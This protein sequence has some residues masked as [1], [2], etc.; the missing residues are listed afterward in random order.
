MR[1][2]IFV[3]RFPVISE[4]FI[5]SKVLAL[6]EAGHDVHLFAALPD[7][8]WA[9]YPQLDALRPMLEA[10]TH[11]APPPQPLRRVL[12]EGSARLL[13]TALR[14]PR[15]FARFV[16]HCWRHRRDHPRGFLKALYTRLNFV[17]AALDLLHIEFDTQG[18]ALV[19]LK[20][21][22]GC[23]L[24]LGSCMPV[25]ETSLLREFPDALSVLYRE[26]NAYHFASHDLLRRAFA[27]GFDPATPHTVIHPAVDAT[28][29]NPS[30]SRRVD[31]GTLRIISVA[32][33]SPFKGYEQNFAAVAT[34]RAAGIKVRYTIVGDGPHRPHIEAEAQRL[35]LLGA[36][37]V[38]FCGA[39]SNAAVADALA[40]ADVML[41]LANSEG[42]GVVALEAQ[43]MGLPVIAGAVGGLPEAIEDGVT[44]FL[45][46]P[47]DIEA[48][49]EK[50]LLL[51]RDPALRLRMG[52]AGRARVLE[53]FSPA[54]QIADTI[55]FYEA[56]IAR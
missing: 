14:H 41:H 13:I 6:L 54:R 4:T 51:A 15:A 50:L 12:I 55:A 1:I 36:D 11:I 38:Q 44:G 2:G 39:L 30:A 43:A 25:E 21:Y 34:L 20:D 53:H 47:D 32:R 10:R 35:G 52:Q 29:F 24:T 19:D 5:V 23:T 16:R 46:A 42:F 40:D 22:L 7:G 9:Y 26:A 33:L 48:A 56:V 31:S 45:V 8:D 28:R 37:I 3:I 17:G 27:Q 49:A 18:Y